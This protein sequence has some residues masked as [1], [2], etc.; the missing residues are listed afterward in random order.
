MF[1]HFNFRNLSPERRRWIFG[2][3]VIFGVIVWITS[4]RVDGTT[5]NFYSFILVGGALILTGGWWLRCDRE[6]AQRGWKVVGAIAAVLFLVGIA[7]FPRP[8]SP[9][10][11]PSRI[12]E[13]NLRPSVPERGDET[14]AQP[15]DQV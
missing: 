8:A 5:A 1:T 11:N 13:E 9:P 14:P 10:W 6:G 3:L 2:A 4:F 7:M 12:P 15:G